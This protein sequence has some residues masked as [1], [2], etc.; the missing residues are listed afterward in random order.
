MGGMNNPTISFSLSLPSSL[1]LPGAFPVPLP[2]PYPCREWN[3]QT[4]SRLSPRPAPQRSFRLPCLPYPSDHAMVGVRMRQRCA[5]LWTVVGRTMDNSMT[6]LEP[7]YYDALTPRVYNV[8]QYVTAVPKHPGLELRNLLY[9]KRL[10]QLQHLSN[11][12]PL[13]IQCVLYNQANIGR[14]F[15]DGS[16]VADTRVTEIEKASLDIF[17][18][19]VYQWALQNVP[20]SSRICLHPPQYLSQH[21]SSSGRFF[22]G[23]R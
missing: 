19:H 14:L 6:N 3:H 5:R 8:G 20:W 16:P 13:E 21:N 4:R 22:F 10:F 18:Q 23:F 7:E 17:F 1:P 12:R 15:P 2:S 9:S 11:Y